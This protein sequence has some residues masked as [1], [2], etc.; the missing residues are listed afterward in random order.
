MKRELVINYFKDIDRKWES[1]SK[2]LGNWSGKC[3]ISLF[4]Y[5]NRIQFNYAPN[6]EPV[7]KFYQ[8]KTTLEFFDD[9]MTITESFED[10]EDYTAIEFSSI[11][12]IQTRLL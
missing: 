12:S 5:G 11:N 4:V 7:S 3:D 6:E 2:T 8:A 10:F 9:Y 1:L